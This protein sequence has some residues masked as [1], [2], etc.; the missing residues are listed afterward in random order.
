MRAV[1]WRRGL[2]EHEIATVMVICNQ[3]GTFV[4]FLYLGSGESMAGVAAVMT[5]A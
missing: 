2:Q 3:D 5:A 4:S 1:S